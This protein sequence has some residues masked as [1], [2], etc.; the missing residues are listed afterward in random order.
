MLGFGVKAFDRVKQLPVGAPTHGV[1]PL[2]HRGIAADLKRERR[3]HKSERVGRSCSGK[4]NHLVSILSNFF[5][6]VW[7]KV[8][9]SPGDILP[10]VQTKVIATETNK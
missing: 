7:T 1:D 6:Q 8:V 2:I 9:S 3:P 4:M 10:S 5:G